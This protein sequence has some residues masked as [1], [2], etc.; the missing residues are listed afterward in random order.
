MVTRWP[1]SLI[2]TKL[3]SIFREGVV[4]DCSKIIAEGEPPV[5]ICILGDPAYSLLPYIIKEFASGGKNEEEQFFG[6]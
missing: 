6:Y 1:G 5:P 4:P 2:N 3:N